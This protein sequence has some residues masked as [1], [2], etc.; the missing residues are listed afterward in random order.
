[1]NKNPI[2]L[3][4][5]VCTS[6]FMQSI[7]YTANTLHNY[8]QAIFSFVTI[9]IMIQYCILFALHTTCPEEIKNWIQM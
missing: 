7:S 9:T 5:H 3:K 8:V 1:M 6:I 2:L 4:V